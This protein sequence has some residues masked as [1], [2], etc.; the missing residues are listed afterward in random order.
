MRDINRIEPF[1][2]ELAIIW[3]EQCPDWRFGQFV[4]NVLGWIQS[5][6]ERD[7]FYIEEKQML[8]YIKEYF[9]L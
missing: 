7:I 8:E 6:K 3:K 9:K 4:S 5:E 2:E 1:M